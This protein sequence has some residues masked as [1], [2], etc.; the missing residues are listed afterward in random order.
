MNSIPNELRVKRIQAGPKQPVADAEWVYVDIGFSA[1][2]KSCG[3]LIGGGEPV[4]ITFTDLIV[5]LQK[6]IAVDTSRPL[7]LVIEAPLSVALHQGG[8]TGRSIEV[9]ETYTKGR[10]KVTPTRYWYAGLGLVVL[11]AATYV[12]RALHDAQPKRPV[13]LYEGFVSF[14]DQEQQS[15]H[16]ADVRA[17]HAA[18]VK[19]DFL[20]PAAKDG[21][22][23]VESA[24][25]VAGMDF[26]VPFIIKG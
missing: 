10:K 5:E 22:G 7:A 23:V 2:K 26:G 8:P 3:L 11:T 20:K 18:R 13:H 17:L 15:D 6:L 21:Q 16:K 4:E 19:G 12:L 25:K 1:T 14:K 24:F 9:G